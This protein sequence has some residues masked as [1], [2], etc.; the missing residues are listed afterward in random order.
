MNTYNLGETVYHE[1]VYWGRE[2]FKVVGIRESELELQGD[3]SGGT[4]NVSQKGWMPVEGILRNKN[5]ETN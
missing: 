5:N 4:H 2:P 3:W 1:D